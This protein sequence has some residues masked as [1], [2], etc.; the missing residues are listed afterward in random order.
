MY[1]LLTGV[2]DTVYVL[3]ICA[4]GHGPLNHWTNEGRVNMVGFF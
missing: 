3:Y 2:V 4:V 1:K